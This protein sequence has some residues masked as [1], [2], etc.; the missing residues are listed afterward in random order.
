MTEI[1][2]RNRFV[3]G[4]IPVDSTAPEA[5]DGMAIP[6]VSGRDEP[7]A[8]T[9]EPNEPAEVIEPGRAL[10]LADFAPPSL[11]AG[12][13]LI[14]LAYRL[15]ISGPALTAPFRKPVRPRLVATVESPMRGD[16]VAG[17]ALRAGHFLILGVKV[18]IGQ[19]D[20]SRS[21]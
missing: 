19:I 12:E 1:S 14:R 2:T 4:A 13:R 7:L 9:A 5:T 21:A 20:F 15:G 18:P 3:T 8:K 6:L 17:T 11:S 16:P 10:A